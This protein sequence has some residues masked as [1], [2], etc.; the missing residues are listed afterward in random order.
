MQF[1]AFED[2]V[3]TCLDLDTVKQNSCQ[4]HTT[5]LSLFRRRPS[6][7]PWSSMCLTGTVLVYFCAIR[8]T[9]SGRFWLLHW[10]SFCPLPKMLSTPSS[11]GSVTFQSSFMVP[12]C[13]YKCDKR[14]DNVP[15]L[16]GC[17]ICDDFRAKS[18]ARL[19]LLCVRSVG[20]NAVH[21]CCFTA[22]GCAGAQYHKGHPKLWLTSRQHV[23]GRDVLLIG[24]PGI[25]FRKRTPHRS[26]QNPAPA[27]F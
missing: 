20:I 3:A 12:P 26:R 9:A 2:Q 10:A 16:C 13:L 14:T 15:S 23:L 27:F 21:C 6:S 24:C 1:R 8:H 25:C 22:C 7:W 19:D 18:A 11:L 4:K 5:K 17:K